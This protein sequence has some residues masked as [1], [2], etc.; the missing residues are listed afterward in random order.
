MTKYLKYFILFSLLF[1]LCGCGEEEYQDYMN[2]IGDGVTCT[3]YPYGETKFT[4][5]IDSIKFTADETGLLVTYKMNGSSV[6]EKYVEIEYDS[7]N[8]FKSIKENKKHKV[9]DYTFSFES[10]TLQN[11]FNNFK[12]NG[13]TCQQN[14]YIYDNAGK[15]YFYETKYS[16]LSDN[17]MYTFTT[18]KPSTGGTTNAGKCQNTNATICKSYTVDTY[19]DGEVN[20]EL[21]RANGQEYYMV[22]NSKSSGIAYNYNGTDSSGV[23]I[24]S[25][26]FIIRAN[27]WDNLFPTSTSFANSI[28]LDEKVIAGASVAHLTVE[29]SQTIT[30][31][32]MFGDAE[33]AGITPTKQPE[34]ESKEQE[35]L[36][37]KEINF[38]EEK[39]VRKTFQI[40]G[41]IL[42]VAKILVPLI[43]IIMGT[44]DFAKATISSDDKAPKE[45]V[46]M[47]IKRILIAVIIFLIPTILSFLLSLVNGASEAFTDSKFTD[48]TDCLLDPFG[49]CKAD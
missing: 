39:G 49:D 1:V 23:K 41:Y 13:N 14:I 43:L 40:V 44:I 22:Y 16:S 6:S 18:T 24:G 26:D 38:C 48:C 29:G 15:L 2:A 34:E 12:N 3:Y 47:L 28:Y 30:D 27:D 8:E 7:N 10:F 21:G 45:A 5:E 9:G 35:P 42:Y 32:E 11:F 31:Y 20:V 25:Y 33:D 46:T 36:E 37:I 4:K 17:A 19:L